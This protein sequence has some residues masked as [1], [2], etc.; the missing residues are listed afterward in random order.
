MMKLECEV[1]EDLYILYQEDDLNPRVK[2]AV[3]E[4]IEQCKK[5]H[6]IYKNGTGFSDYLAEIESEEPSEK[7]DNKIKMRLKLRRLK[8]TVVFLATVMIMYTYFQYMDDRKSLAYESSNTE[9]IINEMRWLIDGAKGQEI[10]FFRMSEMVSN[11]NDNMARIIRHLN[12][13]ERKEY[14]QHPY[15][16]TLSF[17]LTQFLERMNIRYHSDSW[18]EK[19]EEVYQTMNQYFEEYMMSLTDERLKLNHLDDTFNLKA[20]FDSYDVEEIMDLVQKIDQ[21]SYTYYH[22]RKFPNEVK[23]LTKEEAK[24]HLAKIFN[25]ESDNVEILYGLS[26]EVVKSYGNYTYQITASGFSAHGTMDAY[27]GEIIGFN[28]HGG[29]TEGEILPEDQS[30]AALLDMLVRIFGD[31]VE[32]DITKHGL[33]YRYTSNVDHQF[34][35]YELKPIKNGILVKDVMYR[36]FID[37]RSAKV[38]SF[39]ALN[40]SPYIP[41]QKVTMPQGEPIAVEKGKEALETEGKSTFVNTIFIPSLV[42]GK[43]ELVHLYKTEEGPIRYVNTETGKEDFSY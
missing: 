22:F 17:N 42:T 3:N 27:S 23:L 10:R 2:K 41:L 21:L 11:Y 37:S 5:C 25:V 38:V 12:V 16:L 34:Y 1:V 8:I 43:Y 20:K 26:E 30:E 40:I 32:F 15:Q 36:V 4:H 28:S 7:L 13:V 33:N 9:Q 19:D 35:T 18:D 14:S 39:S 31:E 6:S 29:L 24:E